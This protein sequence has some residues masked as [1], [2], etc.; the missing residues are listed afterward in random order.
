MEYVGRQRQQSVFTLPSSVIYLKT[1]S[2]FPDASQ[3]VI[4]TLMCNFTFTNL[5][6]NS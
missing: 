5:H 4:K 3:L 2:L 1:C 6:R